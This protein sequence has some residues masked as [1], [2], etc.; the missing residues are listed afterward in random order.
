MLPGSTKPALCGGRSPVCL[1]E[2]P[3]ATLASGSL[4]VWASGEFSSVVWA[5]PKEDDVL[6]KLSKAGEK[7]PASDFAP[8]DG[9][10]GAPPGLHRQMST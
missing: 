3:R 1:S 8:A 2:R 6:R 9:R 5:G 10:Q 4:A 7:A